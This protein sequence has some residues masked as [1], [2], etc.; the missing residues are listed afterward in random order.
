MEVVMG[1]ALGAGALLFVKKARPMIRRAVGWTARKSGWIASRVKASVDDA[2][3]VARDE[4]A[5]G[6]AEALAASERASA[7]GASKSASA[8]ASS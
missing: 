3:A 2:K 1:L 6:R 5:R 4:F 8:D 7:N